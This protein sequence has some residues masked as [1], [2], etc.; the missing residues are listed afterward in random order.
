MLTTINYNEFG[1][2][3]TEDQEDELDVKRS[4]GG[5][6]YIMSKFKTYSA[7]ERV[8]A[9]GAWDKLSKEVKDDYRNITG[10]YI[11]YFERNGFNDTGY[12]N[13][14]HEQDIRDEEE[15]NRNAMIDQIMNAPT[16]RVSRCSLMKLSTDKLIRV[17]ERL[18][19]NVGSYKND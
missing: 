1:T 19:D 6:G 17:I 16:C 2:K 13:E 12:K 11:P 15:F 5:I 4:K 7:P 18:G 3:Y 9:S 10:K 8:D 14:Q